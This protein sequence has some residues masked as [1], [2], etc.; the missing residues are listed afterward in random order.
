MLPSHGARALIEREQSSSVSCGPKS[1][2][3]CSSVAALTAWI[4][5]KPD[6]TVQERADGG[7]VGRVQHIGCARCRLQAVVGQ[8][9]GPGNRRRSNGSKLN[10]P[11]RREVEPRCAGSHALGPGQPTCNRHLHVG[12]AQLRQHRADHCTR[13]SN[14]RCFADESRPGSARVPVRTASA[15]RSPRVPCSSWSPNRPRSC[16]PSPSWDART[17]SAGV[18]PSQRGGVAPRGTALPTR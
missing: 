14:A 7:F 18:T 6:G 4:A 1:P 16:A 12:C 9:A 5:G 10:A 17:A 11:Q 3:T 8:A 2:A 13:P 15:P